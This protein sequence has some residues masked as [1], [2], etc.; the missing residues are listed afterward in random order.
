MPKCYTQC[1]VDAMPQCPPRYPPPCPRSLTVQHPPR[2]ICKKN[3][4]FTEKIVPEPMVVNGCK[5][6]TIPKVVETTRV[7]RVPKLIWV[8][9]LV[10]EPRV[11]YYP[12]MVPDPYVV[13]HPKKVCEPKEVCTAI[14]CQPKPQK[15]DVP[16][17]TEY[18]CYPVQ[19]PAYRRN[20]D[21][22]QAPCCC[23]NTICPP[24]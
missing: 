14:L 20:E 13:C 11:I 6:I 10:R 12:S 9:Q 21:C 19:K 1:E 22:C 5:Q 17:P 15:I 3:I 16:P 23:P 24:C 8:S 4:V 2:L 18:C 7:I